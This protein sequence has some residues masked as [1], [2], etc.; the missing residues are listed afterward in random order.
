MIHTFSASHP[1]Y[2][3]DS[4]DAS[5]HDSGVGNECRV[6]AI[7]VLRGKVLKTPFSKARDEKEE[8]CT[9]VSE[10]TE[11]NVLYTFPT[12]HHDAC[13]YYDGAGGEY[14]V[15]NKNT[16]AELHGMKAM[17]PFSKTRAEDEEGLQ[18]DV[19]T[20][21]SEETE[22]NVI[23][24]FSTPRLT[25]YPD[26][27]DASTYDWIVGESKVIKKSAKG[28][29]RGEVLETPF[30]SK[31]DEVCTTVSEETEPNVLYTPPV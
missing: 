20:S 24:V 22:P 26:S 31:T 12:P 23:H 13:T 9:T 14:R 15:I 28:V 27:E 29:P 6:S 2:Y 10:E 5:T 30:L 1:T 17:T 18:S 3:P 25:L 21:V 19:C 16:K 4:E 8:V 11:P 7:G